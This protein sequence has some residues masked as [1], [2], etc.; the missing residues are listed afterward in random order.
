M[1]ALGAVDASRVASRRVNVGSW[2]D[3]VVTAAPPRKRSAQRR[4]ARSW[5]HSPRAR[6]DAET[7]ETRHGATALGRAAPVVAFDD[8]EDWDDLTKPKDLDAKAV[9]E[10]VAKGR[11]AHPKAVSE[12]TRKSSKDASDEDAFELAPKSSKSSKP[13]SKPKAVSEK[14][15]K[16]S[17]DASDEDAFE[18][19]PKSSKSSKPRRSGRLGEDAKV[20]ES[21]RL[22]ERRRV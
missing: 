2:R 11:D 10:L 15:R 19:A 12:K 1:A 22:V 9:K 3:T 14:T 5:S 4:W 6:R 20:V 8:D 13:S 16:S 21:R 18:L 7:L 17:K